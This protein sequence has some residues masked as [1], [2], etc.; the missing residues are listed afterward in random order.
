MANVTFLKNPVE[1]SGKLPKVGHKAPDAVL[2]TCDL[3]D[4]RLSDHF[5]RVQVLS[6]VPSL[7]TEVCAM[8]ARRFN[9]KAGA[10]KGVSVLNISLDLP[11]ASGRFCTVE[12]LKNVTTLS[13]FRMREFGE[14]YGLIIKS[15]PLTGLLARAV[16]VIGREGKVVYT[17]L[18]PEISNEPD[19]VLA[20]K[21]AEAAS[22]VKADPD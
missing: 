6:V 2:T 1:L 21:A 11:F 19:Y 5:D 7:D 18:V 3:K 9:E 20:L 22:K 15:G 14:A 17:E 4:Y 16:I 10:L 8:S 13:D 12:S